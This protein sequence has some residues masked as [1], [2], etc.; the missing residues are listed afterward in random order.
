MAKPKAMPKWVTPERQA[1]LVRLW[2]QFG[3]KCLLG[4]QTC[5]NLDHY[6]YREPKAVKVAK[7]VIVP[8]Q[9]SNGEPIRDK[10][11]EPIHIILYRALTSV[12]YEEKQARL[13]ELKS[14]RQID[15]W[16]ADDRGQ[17]QAELK[18]ERRQMHSLGE[19]RYPLRGRFS[20]IAQ[21]IFF[22]RQAQHYLEGLGISGLTFKPFAKVRIASSYMCLFVELGDTLK[23]VSKSKRRK[24]IRY[25]KALPPDTQRRIDILCS[26]AVRHYLK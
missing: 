10:H 19:R 21:D 7:P 1:H 24:A 12:I 26:L 14:E 11:G 16:Q 5:S 3:N 8:C 23:A 18:A 13:Y 4:H 2:A 22:D 25:G 20:N 15:T 6:I 17:R 9:D